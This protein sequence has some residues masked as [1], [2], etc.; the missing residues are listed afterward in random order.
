[1]YIAKQS[2]LR[3]PT[4]SRFYDAKHIK[5][6]CIPLFV[7]SLKKGLR[8]VS[9]ITRNVTKGN[10]G[11]V[12]LNQRLS[13][14]AGYKPQESMMDYNKFKETLLNKIADTIRLL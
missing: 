8:W 11:K 10:D 3:E 1:M 5:K 13:N 6:S 7:A 4:W 12:P 14:L 2:N 9:G